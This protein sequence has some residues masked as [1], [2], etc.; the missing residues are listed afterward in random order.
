M[1]IQHCTGSPSDCKKK[2]IQTEKRE[3]KL[4]LFPD[5]ITVHVEN[6]KESTK[7]FWN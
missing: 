7:T 6:P 4:Y 5:D 2:G 3:I 1:P